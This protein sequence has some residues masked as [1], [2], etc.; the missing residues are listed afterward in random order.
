MK[1]C[2]IQQKLRILYHDPQIQSKFYR[3]NHD[4]I[5]LNLLQSNKLLSTSKAT[6]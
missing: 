2:E 5:G 3:A 6:L 4:S 1:V